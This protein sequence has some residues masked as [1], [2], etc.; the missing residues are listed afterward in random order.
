M[1]GA[2]Q[3]QRFIASDQADNFGVT[4]HQLAL[5]ESEGAGEANVEADRFQGVN[6]HQTQIEFLFQ[7]AQIHGHGFTVDGVGAFTQKMPVAGHFDQRIVIV[8]DAFRT[9]LDLLVGHD[10]VEH[11]RR[12]VDDVAD[13]MGVGA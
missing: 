13:D 3:V 5:G 8:R 6:A 7:L 4:F 9:F 11:G 1:L 10:I 2:G 12:I